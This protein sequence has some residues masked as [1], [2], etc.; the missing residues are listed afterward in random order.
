MPSRPRTLAAL[1]ALALVTG[2]GAPPALSQPAIPTGTPSA[3]PAP[4]SV[5]TP[6]VSPATGLP[7]ALPG[8]TSPST[9]PGLVAAPC[10]SGP[11]GQRIIDLLRGPAAVLP[12]GVRVRVTTG[13]LCAADWQYTVLDVTG[14]EE[15]QVVTRGRSSA[16]E[17]VTAG[18]D[19]C[20]AEVRAVGAPGIRTLACDGGTVGM[21]GA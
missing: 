18:T 7:S 16:P 1:A 13:P 6:P 10:R 3:P 12:D 20:T 2:C 9:D 11:T 15:L 19:V 21:T 5:P 4:T 17:L 8:L 14:H